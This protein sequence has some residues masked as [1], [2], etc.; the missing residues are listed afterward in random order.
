MSCFASFVSFVLRLLT[1][2]IVA[3]SV[4]AAETQTCLSPGLWYTLT[5]SSPKPETAHAILSDI[6]RRQVVLLGEHHDDADHHR[7]QLQ[8]LAALAVLQPRMVIGF[9]ALPRRTQP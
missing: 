2:C 8:T 5:D 6:S 7:W 1:L 9:E 3:S 4:N